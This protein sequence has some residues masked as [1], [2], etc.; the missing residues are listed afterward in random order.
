MKAVNEIDK[1]IGNLGYFE[2]LDKEDKR[3][4]VVLDNVGI[5]AQV[6]YI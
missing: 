3:F 2:N 5:Q 4:A 1:S 6:I